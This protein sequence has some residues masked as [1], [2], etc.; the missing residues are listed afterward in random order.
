[1]YKSTPHILSNIIISPYNSFDPIVYTHYLFV[2]LS[3]KSNI[4][5]E[6][7]EQ[8][9]WQNRTVKYT[10]PEKWNKASFSLQEG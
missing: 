1:M 9:I 6:R 8:N 10:F 7:A 5:K 3:A 2:Q 4:R